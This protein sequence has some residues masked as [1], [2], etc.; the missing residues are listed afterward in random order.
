MKI[1]I[2]VVPNA[3]NNSIIK[4]NNLLKVYVKKPAIDNKANKEIIELLGKFFEVKK[5]N[6]KIIKGEKSR[7]KIVEISK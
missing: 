3:K 4:E 6:V 1:G 5:K 2:K 7:N